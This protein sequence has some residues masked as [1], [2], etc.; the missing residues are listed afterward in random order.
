L[1]TIGT[2]PKIFSR[3]TRFLHL[4]HH[5]KE[6]ENKNMT[7]LTYDLGYYDQAHFIKDFRTFTGFTPK[8]F[9]EQNNIC[10]ADF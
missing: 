9:Y 2:T 10:F 7:Q 1:A 3:T 6:Y 4:C 5:L 8:E